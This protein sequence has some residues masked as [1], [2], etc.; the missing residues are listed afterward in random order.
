MMKQIDVSI[1]ILNY[2]TKDLLSSC[3]T[4]LEKSEK[5]PYTFETIV[6]DNGSTDGSDKEIRKKFPWVKLIQNGNNVGFAAGNN[7]GISVSKGRYILLLNSDTEVSPDTIKTMV[8][9]MDEH[10][11]IGA[12]TCKLLLTDGSMDPAC[13]RGMTSP[14]VGFTYFSKLEK[15]FP[16]TKLFG[17]YHQ[18]Y[19]DLNSS[20]EVD[21]ISGAFF[22]VRHDV[23]LQVGLLD[24]DYF[25]YAEDIDYAYR[26]KKAGYKIWFYP[27]VTVLHKKKQSGR[28]HKNKELRKQT[29]T[30]F[31]VSNRLFY[32]KHFE[33]LYPKI[34]SVLVYSVFD[35]QMWFIKI[36]GV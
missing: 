22:M 35:L 24:E 2:N 13:H 3:L 1:I 12:S 28:S 8:E 30:H 34:L 15:L 18:G 36:F 11:T 33:K 14:W 5:G 20:H 32:T 27:F 10:P 21:V 31:I 4:A 29:Q 6:C 17:E 23:V 19:K 25:M 26:I 9:F 7:P 16:K